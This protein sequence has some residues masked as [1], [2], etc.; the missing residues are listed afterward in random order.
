M[1]EPK[2]TVTLTE[3]NGIDARHDRSIKA[4]DRKGR[5]YR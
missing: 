3:L 5:D 2:A 4:V 1:A